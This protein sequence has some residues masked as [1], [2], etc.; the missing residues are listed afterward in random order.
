MRMPGQGRGILTALPSYVAA[1]AELPLSAQRT[2]GANGAVVVVPG[3]GDWWQ[4]LLAARARGAV[5]VVIADP[6]EL[7]R[8]ALEANPWS[9]G[10]PVVVE[11]PRLRPDVVADAVRAR[12]GS[13]ARII[14]VE[15]A[16]PGAGLQ[17]VVR[18]GLGWARSLTQGT[19]TLQAC[20][21]SARG[22]IA[23]LDSAKGT[24]GS[25]PTTLAA[26]ETA[27]AA[28]MRDGGLLQLLALGE[29]RTEV[30][31]DQPAGLMRLET[32]TEDGIWRAS[33][34]YESSARLALR[35]ALEAC[36]SGEPVADLD[37]ML[38]DISLTTALLG[39]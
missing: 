38:E 13:P 12:G 2:D 10:I 19:L 28:G 21:A 34:H 22:R 3:S 11:R 32:S 20:V 30:I 7:P 15:C 4:G 35:R 16:S 18:D 29:V 33:A 31:V 27:A 39:T 17:A 25:L 6:G 37:E 36:A 1:V 9:G 5:A 24:G 8:K 23:L 26:T 14:T